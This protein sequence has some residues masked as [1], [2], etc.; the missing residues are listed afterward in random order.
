[1]HESGD[2]ADI[3]E[4]YRRL[5][6]TSMQPDKAKG[7]VIPPGQKV[8]AE[9]VGALIDRLLDDE[10]EGEGD[11]SP[12]GKAGPDGER[13][14]PASSDDERRGPGAERQRQRVRVEHRCT[15]ATKESS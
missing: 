6:T 13:E 7:F 15:R 14:G 1:M 2:L 5:L 8:T 10:P 3:V 12:G 11:D 9:Q 4:E